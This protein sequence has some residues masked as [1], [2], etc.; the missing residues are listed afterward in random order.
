MSG[1]VR[2]DGSQASPPFPAMGDSNSVQWN[3]TF[4]KERVSD[5]E[6]RGAVVS[7]VVHS[8]V[9][10]GQCPG[11]GQARWAEHAC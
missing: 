5:C 3:R 9:A 2:P 11:G 7:V 10:M 6:W 1:T 4:G 8:G